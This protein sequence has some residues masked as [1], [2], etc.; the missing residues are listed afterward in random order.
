MERAR[1]ARK[2]VVEIWSS[3]E[4]WEPTA[5]AS[6]ANL[7]EA[8]IWEPS[9]QTTDS[10]PD[11]L[12]PRGRWRPALSIADTLKGLGIGNLTVLDSVPGA[13]QY[14][15]E[16]V[17]GT[18]QL[19][20][21]LGLSPL[22]RKKLGMVRVDLGTLE[23][24]V[25]SRIPEFSD[26]GTVARVFPRGEQLVAHLS[27]ANRKIDA[28]I[29]S[30]GKALVN[31]PQRRDLPLPCRGCEFRD[32]R[33]R[34]HF[35]PGTKCPE[36]D[37][38]LGT[39]IQASPAHSWRI[40]GLIESDG[41]PTRRGIVF[42]FFQH[43]EGLA[44]AAALEDRSYRIDELVFDLANLRAGLR[45]SGD[46]SP[47]SGRLAIVCQQT[48]ARAELTGYLEMGVPV[49]Y[50][51]GAS[52]VVR[53]MILHDVPRQKLL[54]ESLRMGDLERAVVEWRSLLRHV[55]LAPEYPW[56]RWTQLREAAAEM[57]RRLEER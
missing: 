13:K 7:G 56:D 24:Q 32:E 20:G 29:D 15:R 50:G 21:T 26:S 45:F 30:T 48:Y 44:V 2:G 51:A 10:A 25:L 55:A 5:V 6:P 54:T 46:E 23:Q 52:E 47:Y 31:P 3:E 11:D 8:W 28:V 34:E 57:L 22:M 19:G 36:L 33:A 4:R 37:W 27:Y 49:D 38:C 43:G 1:F 35:A 9:R 41:T 14:G 16:L 18:R 17:I 40:L 12:P 39:P 53:D 42:S